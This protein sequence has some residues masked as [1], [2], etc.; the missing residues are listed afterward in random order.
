MARQFY[1]PRDLRFHLYEVLDAERLMQLPYFADHDRASFGMVLDAAGQI[2]ETLLKP[3]LTVMDRDEPQLVDGKIRV[4]PQLEPIIRKFGE[5][6]WMN[7]PFSYDEG[8]QQPAPGD[9]ANFY[10]GKLMAAR[11]FYEYELVKIHGL[12]KRLRSDDRVTVEMKNE[13]F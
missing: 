10:Q 6:G 13:W 11:Y 2:S 4:H 8:G 12:S 1:S 7:A 5:D 9:D 3:L